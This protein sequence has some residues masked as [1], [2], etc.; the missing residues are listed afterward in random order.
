MKQYQPTNGTYNPGGGGGTLTSAGSSQRENL[1]SGTSGTNKGIG[2][3]AR[4]DYDKF[5]PI[6]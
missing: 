1:F 6:R 2:R 3:I 4:G 5:S